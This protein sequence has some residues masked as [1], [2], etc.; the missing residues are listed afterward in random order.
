MASGGSSI[1][2]NNSVP[3]SLI[4]LNTNLQTVAV[5]ATLHKTIH[6]SLIYLLP[7]DRFNIADLEHLLAQ[8]PKPFIYYG[9]F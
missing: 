5:N 8:L 4:P 3:Q 9:R 1:V 7:G 6:V 2:V